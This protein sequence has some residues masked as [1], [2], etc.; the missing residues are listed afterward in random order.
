MLDKTDDRIKTWIQKPRNA[1]MKLESSLFNRQL[2]I[3]LRVQLEGELVRTIKKNTLSYVGHKPRG[4]RGIARMKDSC[5][6][7]F[8]KW[9]YDQSVDCYVTCYMRK[10]P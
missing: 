9:N 8:C 4:N 6:R 2:N 7:K 1:F 3:Q 5:L 10:I